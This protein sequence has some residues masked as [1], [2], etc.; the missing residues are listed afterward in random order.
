MPPPLLLG[1]KVLKPNFQSIILQTDN[2]CSLLSLILAKLRFLDIS[3]ENIFAFSIVTALTAFPFSI[4]KR[5]KMSVF[6]CENRKNFQTPGCT[7][8]CQILRAPL[9]RAPPDL[10]KFLR[11]P[12]TTELDH[13][14]TSLP[15]KWNA[16]GS[17]APPT[18]SSPV[19]APL[20]VYH[21]KM[22]ESC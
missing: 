13:S 10:K 5:A 7:P 22:G 2:D 12:L 14:L 4:K 3:C 6:L 9:L 20:S 16:K 19:P 17:T 1:N 21:T 18:P 15:S 8:L 11:T